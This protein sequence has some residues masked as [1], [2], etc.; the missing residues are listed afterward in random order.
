M[1]KERKKS[2]IKNNCKAPLCF[3]WHGN[4][5]SDH[6]PKS[7]PACEKRKKHSNE[8]HKCIKQEVEL[9]SGY[10]AETVSTFTEDLEK[11]SSPKAKAATNKKHKRYKFENLSRFL[12]SESKILCNEPQ[13]IIFPQ[14]LK[15]EK[16]F[17]TLVNKGNLEKVDKFLKNTS[18]FNVNCTDFQGQTPLIIAIKNNNLE[19]VRLLLQQDN[20]TIADAILHA[21]KVGNV[22]IL[23]LVLDHINTTNCRIEFMDAPSFEFP[24]Y[25]TPLVLAAEMGNF[26]IVSLLLERG[27][28]IPRPH[29]PQCFCKAE[30]MRIFKSE[31]P[32]T[33]ANSK[34]HV[35]SALS[36]P[37][38]ICQMANDPILAAFKLSKELKTAGLMDMVNKVKYYKL[39]KDVR[40]FAAQ[41]AALCYNKEEVE[42]ILKEQNE[43]ERKTTSY[44]KLKK[45]I[46]Y[47]QKEFIS[48]P[49]IQ[50][51]VEELWSGRW[52]TWKT[53]SKPLKLFIIFGRVFCLPFIFLSHCCFPTSHWSNFHATPINR[54]INYL[55]SY[56]VFLVFVTLHFYTGKRDVDK[57]WQFYAYEPYLMWFTFTSMLSNFLLWYRQGRNYFK[58]YLN[59]YCMAVDALFLITSVFWLMSISSHFSMN[60]LVENNQNFFYPKQLAENLFGIAAIL[61]Y[62]KLIMFC[63]MEYHLGL[64]L[65]FIGKLLKPLWSF[66]L[67]MFII[68]IAFAQASGIF[69]SYYSKLFSIET[70]EKDGESSFIS[71]F[72]TL[73]Y[74]LFGTFGLA[75]FKGESNAFLKNKPIFT[76]VVGFAVFISFLCIISSLMVFMLVFMAAKSQKLLDDLKI[77]W[78]YRRTELILHFMDLPILPPPLNVLPTIRYCITTYKSQHKNNEMEKGLLQDEKDE[79]L[80]SIVISQLVQRY[81]AKAS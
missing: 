45:A 28:F 37:V 73:K 58:F 11:E 81:F 4:Q 48:S 80:S 1:V 13:K 5:S 67:I 2:G 69:H 34:L 20:I 70:E 6:V 55:S 57:D 30:C 75:A 7:C 19:M 18:N 61:A 40:V 66:F 44:T 14:L 21:V 64:V 68:L 76:E 23:Q 15:N 56:F 53:Y 31:D 46:L 9:S 51:K 24:P 59:R 49:N 74:F 17:H 12:K 78:I 27:H 29:K 65:I 60:N 26:K 77:E 62:I 54:F 3:C 10:T 41:L 43:S 36:N 50:Y 35:Y 25:I 32:V 63:Q 22:E 42:V 8:F 16:Y 52:Y 47:K 79:E 33:V 71:P 38:Y 72:E 39:A